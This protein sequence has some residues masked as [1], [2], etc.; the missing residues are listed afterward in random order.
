MVM[1]FTRRYLSTASRACLKERVSLHTG[2]TGRPES[3]YMILPYVLRCGWPYGPPWPAC[4]CRSP[5]CCPPCQM[6]RATSHGLRDPYCYLLR[7]CCW[8][9]LRTARPTCA[10]CTPSWSGPR[11][12]P[13]GALTAWAASQR[14][15][16]TGTPGGM[17]APCLTVLGLPDPVRRGYCI[18]PHKGHMAQCQHTLRMRTV[19]DVEAQARQGLP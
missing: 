11:A 12:A 14:A 4:C 8:P 13:R 1:S 15:R 19:M 6:S 3:S 5:H 17:D 2:F 16:G 10:T 18:H 7:S 9:T